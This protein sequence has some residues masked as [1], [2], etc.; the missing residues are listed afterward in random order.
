[1]KKVKFDVAANATRL[2]ETAEKS[3]DSR[4]ANAE[5]T[6]SELPTGLSVRTPATFVPPS[7]YVHPSTLG[8][9]AEPARGTIRVEIS[10]VRDN[11]RNARKVYVPEV[12]AE[13]AASIR[14]HGQMTPA[15]A[16]EDWENPGCYILIGGHYRKKALLHNQETHIELKLLPVT[17][18]VE[19]YLLSYVENAERASGTPLDDAL[20]WK[21]LLD[22]GDVS[23]QEQISSM[24]GK[25]RTTIGKTLALLSL[26]EAVLDVLKDAPD[27]FTLTAG[28]ELSTMAG[29]FDEAE[30]VSIAQR[31]AEG[32]ISTRDLDDIKKQRKNLAHRK[33]K[34]FSRQ[35]KIVNATGVHGTIKDWDSGKIL[36]ELQVSDAAE[37]ERLV[38]EL[39]MK[40]SAA[41][42]EVGIPNVKAH[43]VGES[44]PKA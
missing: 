4:W 5:K 8:L 7:P 12:I 20:A 1:M 37:R 17:N 6:V 31:I 39:R 27:K 40:F 10:K 21:E 43:P 14:Q 23:S 26:S 22:S 29:S 42:D 2:M 35:H 44:A 3:A 34:E 11:P 19:L 33:P 36:I 41:G 24:V 9:G 30:L 15:P 38:N 16:C 13:R 25:P 28:Y 32:H 18:N